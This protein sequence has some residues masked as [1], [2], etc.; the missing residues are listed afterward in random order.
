MVLSG[1]VE[2]T[3]HLLIVGGIAAASWLLEKLVKPTPI[4]GTPA[5]L[6]VKILSLFGFFIGALLLIT[7][8]NASISQAYD[9]GTIYLLIVTGLALVLRPLKD[10]PWA[11]L[12]GL[13][14]GALCVSLVFIF[15]PL[16]E[17][18]FGISSTWIY[19]GVF[20]IPALM[21][22]VFFKFAEDLLRLVGMILASKPVS[23]VLGLT[24]I[25]QGILLLLNTSLFTI[26]TA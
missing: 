8:I 9:S 15:Y 2:F 26:L 6:T 25:I 18:V 22:Y 4:I 17:A 14:V 5:S 7:G 13:L 1:L 19:F 11:A 23:I 10:I 3:P 12:F 24:C 21:V 16:P 20:I